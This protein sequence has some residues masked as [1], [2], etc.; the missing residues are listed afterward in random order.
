MKLK[1]KENAKIRKKENAKTKKR[2]QNKENNK[3]KRMPNEK[4]MLLL[5]FVDAVLLPVLRIGDD[6]ARAH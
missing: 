1:N 6:A 5:L 4:K 2:K 3:K